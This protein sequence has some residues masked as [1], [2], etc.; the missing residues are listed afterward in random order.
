MG[1]LIWEVI[2]KI[3]KNFNSGISVINTAEELMSMNYFVFPDVCL[4]A[5]EYWFNIFTEDNTI[6]ICYLNCT[7][8][9]KFFSELIKKYP[10]WTTAHFK[11]ALKVSDTS[12]Y[13]YMRRFGYKYSCV[14]WSKPDKSKNNF[15][16]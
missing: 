1:I 8:R 5:V 15:P 2:D 16:F 7:F 11:D 9:L 14:G 13:A 4:A 3:R 12:I 10:T 6:R